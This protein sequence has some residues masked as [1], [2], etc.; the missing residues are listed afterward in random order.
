MQAF[1]PVQPIAT[2][3]HHRVARSTRTTHRQGL[4]ASALTPRQARRA[5]GAP[6]PC[7]GTRSSSRTSATARTTGSR[8]RT[9]SAPPARPRRVMWRSRPAKASS[10]IPAPPGIAVVHE[11]RR[12]ERRRV[13]RHRHAADVPPVA[14]GEQ[15]EQPDQRVL[16]GMH[17]AEH[18]MRLDPGR[19]EL[20]V[21]ERVPARSGR[22]R[23]R[24]EIERHDLDRRVRRRPLALEREDRV[25]HVDRAEVCPSGA[26]W[27]A[28]VLAR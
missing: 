4:T 14:D 8:P 13:E 27:H 25:R 19:D 12:L 24:W 5:D 28:L 17:G 1:G 18:L 23:A 6:R 11:D 26:A 3:D 21:G 2:S 9:G 7:P 22:Q 10:A 16:G 15:R 20:G